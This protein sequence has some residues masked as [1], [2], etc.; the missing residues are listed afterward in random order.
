MRGARDSPHLWAGLTCAVGTLT[1]AG[2]VSG[3]GL[4]ELWE[5]AEAGLWTLAHAW[6]SEPGARSCEGV[7]MGAQMLGPVV[8]RMGE[9]DQEAET[10][11]LG[12]FCNRCTE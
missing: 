4:S 5:E 7:G 2:W 3:P 11:L 1:C 12:G 6:M 10:T 9:A 8:W